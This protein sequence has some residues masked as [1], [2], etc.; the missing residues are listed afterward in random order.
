MTSTIRIRTTACTTA[1]VAGLPGVDSRRISGQAEW[2]RTMISR[3]GVRWEPFVDL[4]ADAYS[5]ADL[6]PGM[7]LEEETIARGRATAGLDVSYPLIRRLGDAADLILEPMAQ[8][9][10]SNDPDLDPR[11]PNEDSQTL[12]L[13]QSS[14]FRTDRF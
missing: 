14:L 7:G 9:S 6:P 4:R 3:A 11:I 13:D 12:E 1:T 10:A 8:F 5:I 2:R